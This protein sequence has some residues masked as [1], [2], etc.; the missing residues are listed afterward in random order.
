MAATLEGV[1]YIGAE[2]G[3]RYQPI[4]EARIAHAVAYPEQWLDTRPGPKV[5]DDE[6][7]RADIEAAGQ[8]DLFGGGL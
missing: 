3:E 1:A 5:T 7:E 4:A 8:V 2:L 6:Q